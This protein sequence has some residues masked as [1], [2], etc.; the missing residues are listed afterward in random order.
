M[1]KYVIFSLLLVTATSAHAASDDEIRGW[2]REASSSN[3]QA[4]KSLR[5]SAEIGTSL[6]QY[7][8]GRLHLAGAVVARDDALTIAW[9]M[10]A[11]EQGYVPAMHDLAVVLE[12]A[13]GAL[14]DVPAAARWY[15]AAADKGHAPAQTNLGVLYQ[16]GMGVSRNLPLAAELFR[17]AAIQGEVRAQHNLGKLHLDGN[18][19]PQDYAEARRW[20]EAAAAKND[21]AALF[22]LAKLYASG[23]SVPKDIDRAAA[24]TR[25][26]S[27]RN[28]APAQYMHAL[29]FLV[30]RP[31]DEGE[32]VRWLKRAAAQGYT[33]AEYS[34]G[35]MLG[36]GR[37]VQQD[38]IESLAWLQKAAD[39]GHPGAIDLLRRT[40]A[41]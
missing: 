39:K 15:Q 36:E 14:R 32:V 30:R 26:A 22:S 19:V 5:E 23:H 8:L 2:A 9:F 25:Q 40:S 31:P 3:Q 38:L 20:F 7:Y 41:R 1:M 34:L 17:K 37:G 35:V 29:S 24:L 21:G 33:D 16:D 12:R 13:P 11:A 6:A 28:Y 18:G 27:Q 4:L 10:K